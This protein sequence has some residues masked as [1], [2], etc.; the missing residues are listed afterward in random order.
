MTY[1]NVEQKMSGGR[2]ISSKWVLFLIFVGIAPAQTIKKTILYSFSDGDDGGLPFAGV[3]LAPG[4]ELYGTTSDGGDSSCG[5]EGNRCGTLYKLTP[6]ALQGEAWTEATLYTFGEGPDD[7][8]IP[9]TGVAMDRSGNFY[10]T[11]TVP[12]EIY[13]LVP[14]QGGA[15]EYTAIYGPSLSVLPDP[16]VDFT[17]SL[18][19]SDPTG[20][21]DG[22]V[23][24]LSPNG[25]G[26][27]KTTVLYSFPGGNGGVFPGPIMGDRSG[28]IYGTTAAGG[29]NKCSALGCGTVFVLL[30]PTQSGGA[31]S[32]KML[33]N[34]EGGARG[35]Y[36]NFGLTRDAQGNL[37]GIAVSSQS[38]GNTFCNLVFELS[39]SKKAE[40]AWVETVLHVFQGGKDGAFLQG[41]LT[42]DSRGNLYGTS[43]FGGDGP[44]VNNG[45]LVGCGTVFRLRRPVETSGKWI[46]EVLPFQ[47]GSDGLAPYGTLVL[48]EVNHVLYGTTSFGGIY[49]QGTVFEIT[50]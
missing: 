40:A 43:A 37:Y 29:V 9:K 13:Q 20:N 27:F 2:S 17:G 44:C 42:I 11:T 4:G 36:P 21:G 19:D 33:Y 6:P 41:G 46:E 31:W 47:G 15:S 10:G 1:W 16:I 35:A 24:K 39:P 48:D 45:A 38:C 7:G 18:Y 25:D 26:T 34:F 3:R 12:N 22:S 30:P 14:Q 50:E 32:H 49:N 8:T 28:R 5:V 23:F